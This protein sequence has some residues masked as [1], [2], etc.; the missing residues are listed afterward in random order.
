M[1]GAT[2]PG[3]PTSG[4]WSIMGGTGTFAN[5][6]GTIKYRDVPSTVSRMTDVVKELDI[7][8]FYASE[9]SG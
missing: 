2:V 6:Q 9:I 4:Q 3:N 1:L 8:I 7:R 5:A